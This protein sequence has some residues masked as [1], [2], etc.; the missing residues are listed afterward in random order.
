V[1]P[2]GWVSLLDL[3]LHHSWA[4]ALARAHRWQ[5]MLESGAHGSIAELAAAE[6][7]N[8]SYLAR[9]LRL[10]LLAPDIVEATLDGRHN[11]ERTTL[12]WLM[13]PFPASWR[14]SASEHWAG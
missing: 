7:I 1:G 3:P 2:S 4:A 9:V 12:K 8:P 11:P 5:G 14:S 6:G 10:T 13:R